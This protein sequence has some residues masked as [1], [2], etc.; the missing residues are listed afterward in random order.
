MEQFET[1]HLSYGLPTMMGLACIALP[2]QSTR[3]HYDKQPQSGGHRDQARRLQSN[4]H[5]TAVVSR[6]PR[7]PGPRSQSPPHKSGDVI[8]C[9]PSKASVKVV[10]RVY[11][12]L[13]GDCKTPASDRS[14]VS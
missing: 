4:S 7:R 6:A 5:D 9:V 2:V 14:G 1:S 3:A 11:A 10:G 13:A 12:L 8:A